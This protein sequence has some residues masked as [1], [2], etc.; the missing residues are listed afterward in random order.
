MNEDQARAAIV[1][2]ARTW[3]HTPYH[4]LADVKGAGV[5][6]LML[7]VRVFHEVGLVPYVDPRPYSA[8]W[9]LHRTEEVYLAG[10]QTYARELGLDEDSRPGDIALWKFGRAYSHA[11]IVVS[12]R[13]V[14]HALKDAHEVTVADRWAEPLCSRPV[15]YFS[16]F[17]TGQ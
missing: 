17:G 7:L 11:G 9:H 6:C 16:I 2:E 1:E 12:E 10:L 15:K 8:Q 14:I 3:L 4:P 13:E 5:D